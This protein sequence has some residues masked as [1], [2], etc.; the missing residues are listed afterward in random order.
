MIKRLI[1]L[2]MLAT[3]LTACGGGGNTDTTTPATST[4]T[5]VTAHL[6][7]RISI[8]GKAESNSTVTVTF[9]DGSQQT[10]TAGANGDYQLTSAGAQLAGQARVT[11][12]NSDGTVSQ[13]IILSANEINQALFS[14]IDTTPSLS[15]T[16]SLGINTEAPQGG[17]DTAGLPMPFVD[18]F[19]TARPFKELSPVG[20][21]YDNN[22]W[23]TEF[24]SGSNF[25]RTKL[26]QGALKGSIPNGQYTVLYDGAGSLEFGSTGTVTN[27]KKISGENKYT[28]NF[29]LRDFAGD[30][31]AAAAD[32]N[33]INMNIKNIS[34]GNGNYMKNIRIVMPG[35][36][37]SGNPFLRVDSDEDCPSGT[38]YESFADRLQTNRNAIIFN[39]DYLLFLRNFKVIRMMNLMEASLKRLCFTAEDCPAVVGTWDHRAKMNDAVWGGNDGRTA[40]EDHNGVP[41]EVMIALANTIKRDIWVNMPHIASNN[42]V[43]QFA[44]QV[45]SQLNPSLKVY[46]EYTNE[47]WNSGFAGYNYSISEGTKLSLDTVPPDVIAYCDGLSEDIRLSNTRCFGDYYAR[48]RFYSQRAVEIF[49]LWKAEFNNNN[50]RLVRVLGSF[51]GDTTLTDLML[52]HVGPNNVDAVAIAPYFFGCP[53]P[54]RCP[55]AAKS[56]LTAQTVDDIFEVI[57]QLGKDAEG[58]FVDVKS[59]DGT[60]DSIK[61]QLVVTNSKGVKLLTY[62]GGQHLVTG[63]LGSSASASEQTRLRALF[64]NANRD[65]RM[66]QRYL[67]LLNE[68]KNLSNDGTTLFTLYTLPQSYYRFG[69]FGIKEHL[70]K[71]R[72][73]SPKFDGAM[74]FQ[75]SVGD[76]WWVGVGCR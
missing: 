35:G 73:E 40:D 42:Y 37:C 7:G 11:S 61:R 44:R 46:I 76:C 4:N 12:T 63:V 36:T 32:T 16:P 41:V 64:N 43:T 18:I 38:T 33:A 52:E 14:V 9:P 69:N 75:E 48:L 59:L 49:N 51:I 27:I 57:D 70:N 17:A 50:T 8:S 58:N 25:A 15:F 13:P 47:V 39:P 6:D 74:E 66:K 67:R 20:T 23:P 60:I 19:R 3:L 29:S 22:G 62:E 2:V 21:S 71:P 55:R 54:E 45:S 24:A 56:L 10:T 34:A 26:L 1:I 5:T 28:F 31:G 72:S 53:A 68:W 65:P 30:G